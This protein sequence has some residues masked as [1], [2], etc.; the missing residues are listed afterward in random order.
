M[1][2]VSASSP[3]YRLRRSYHVIGQ[4]CRGIYEAFV[5]PRAMGDE[6]CWFQTYGSLH[7]RLCDDE[8][9]DDDD[10]GGGGGGDEDDHDDDDDDDDD[11]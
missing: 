11:C 4:F 10:D 2:G 1:K 9:D 5:W 3:F 7:E 8:D 6:V